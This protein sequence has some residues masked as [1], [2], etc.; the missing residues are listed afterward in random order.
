M[1]PRMLPMP[2]STAAAKALT[3]GMKPMVLQ[4]PKRGAEQEAGGAAEGAADDERAGDG[5][6]DVDAHQGRGR[7]VLG[8]AADAA[9]EL[10]AG[11]Q[12][13]EEDHHHDG[14]DD[15]DHL[16]QRDVRPPPIWTT[17]LFWSKNVGEDVVRSAG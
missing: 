11:D 10:G 16:Q 3:P 6:V 2:P 7:R 9:A 8:D 17:R 1:A 13:V 5:L 12:P 15:D 4:K 14:G